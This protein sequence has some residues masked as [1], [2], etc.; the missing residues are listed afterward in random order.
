[1]GNATL[2][3]RM[4]DSQSQQASLLNEIA[5]AAA[6]ASEALDG[7]RRYGSAENMAPEATD[8]RDVIQEAVRFIDGILQAV[9]RLQVE[10]PQEAV[11]T[12]VDPLTAGRLVCSCMLAAQETLTWIPP[13]GGFL[14]LPLLLRLSADDGELTPLLEDAAHNS[15]NACAAEPTKASTACAVLS[16]QC[17]GGVPPGRTSEAPGESHGLEHKLRENKSWR[18]ACHL[19]QRLGC[20][21]ELKQTLDQAALQ[22]LFPIYRLDG[23]N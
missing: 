22:L 6:K 21:L 12:N 10:Y 23:S 20:P 3:Q 15:E 11:W 19:A 5:K 4:L 2:L 9:P 17:T 16:I 7:L 14:P 1:M 18:L 8:L 13:E